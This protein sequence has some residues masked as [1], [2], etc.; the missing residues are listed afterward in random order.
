M[1]LCVTSKSQFEGRMGFQ[2]PPGSSAFS[3]LK[4][5]PWH[6]ESSR[7]LEVPLQERHAGWGS[8]RTVIDSYVQ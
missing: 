6:S 7:Q 5:I 4:D 8:E 1:S 2:M 3:S